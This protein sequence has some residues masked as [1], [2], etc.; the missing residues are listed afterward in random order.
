[1]SS[2]HVIVFVPSGVSS[3]TLN[4]AL[5]AVEARMAPGRAAAARRAGAGAARTAATGFTEKTAAMAKSKRMVW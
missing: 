4:D 3:V 5:S 1:M 2:A